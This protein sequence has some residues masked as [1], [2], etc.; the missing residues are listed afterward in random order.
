MKVT[1]WTFEFC[2]NNIGVWDRMWALSA[3]ELE[4]KRGQLRDMIDDHITPDDL[5]DGSCG[6]HSTP[7]RVEVEL[8]PRGL[9]NF[10]EE[11]AVDRGA[12]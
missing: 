11:Y 7:A 4:T 6:Q 5:L 12:A 10:A 8:T 1:L 9:L 2:I 3:D